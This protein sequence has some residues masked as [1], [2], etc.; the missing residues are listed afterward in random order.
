MMAKGTLLTVGELAKRTG[1]TVRT[2]HHYDRLGLVVPTG[3]SNGNYRLYGADDVQRLQSVRSLQD[4]GFS[5]KRIRLMMDDPGFS[6]ERAIEMHLEKVKEKIGLEKTLVKRL[7]TMRE[8]LKARKD[9]TLDDVVYLLNVTTNV[10]RFKLDA[11][12]EKKLTEHWAGLTRADIKAVEAEWPK[13]IA[14]VRAHMKK[15]TD[16][17]APEVQKLAKRWMELVNQ[18][19][20]GIDKVAKGVARNYEQNYDEI[21]REHGDAIPDKDMFPYVQAALAGDGNRKSEV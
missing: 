14:K 5:L 11:K 20:A 6:F 8:L 13:L 12:E 4:A 10:K 9:P 3:R 7:E 15:G 2:L 1:I 16:P 18:F 17:K 19:T 21:K